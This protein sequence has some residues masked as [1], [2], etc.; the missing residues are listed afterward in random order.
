M[1]LFQITVT[2]TARQVP[3]ARTLM[4]QVHPAPG[5]MDLAGVSDVAVCRRLL[6]AAARGPRPIARY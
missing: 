2:R 4:S 6:A 5:E 1:S 3:K